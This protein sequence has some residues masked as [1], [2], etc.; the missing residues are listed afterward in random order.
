MLNKIIHI[1][2][3]VLSINPGSL[4]KDIKIRELDIDRKDLLT[5]V[6]DIEDTYDIIIDYSRLGTFETLGDLESYVE[7]KI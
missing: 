2:S 4:H 5:V 1:I 3:N 7:S 6:T